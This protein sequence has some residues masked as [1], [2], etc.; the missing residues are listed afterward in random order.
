MNGDLFT[1][2]IERKF[3]PP[4]EFQVT[5]HERLRQGV[6]E[7]HRKQL[8]VAPTGAGKCL[9]RDTPVLMAD[10]TILPVQ[11]VQ[12]G[13]RLLGPDGG[14]RNVLSVARGREQLYR[15]IPKKGASYVCNA[16]HI[17][18]LRKT[19]GSDA[20]VLADGT[21][22]DPDAD[23]VNV[24][25][26]VFA[27]SNKTARHCL[28]GWRSEAIEFPAERDDLMLD[29]YLLGC[30]LGDGSQNRFAI[31]KPSCAMVEEW[32]AAAERYGYEVIETS[33]TG[34]CP[35]WT[36]VSRELFGGQVFNFYLAALDT[37]GL[38]A[39]KHIPH[40]YKI[41]PLSARLQLLAG[42]ID[43]DGSVGHAG[44]DWISKWRELAED[45][46]F[47]CR[48]VGLS[49]YVAPAR[50][51]IAATG[52]VGDYW[53][54][55]VSGDCSVIPCRDKPAPARRQKKRHLVHG[56]RV[57][58]IGEGEYFGFEIDGD[59]LFLLGDFT[60]THN[61]YL[62]LRIC[63]EAIQRGKRTLFVCDRTA[64]IEQTS[65]RA[66]QYGLTHHGIVQAEHWRRD[67]HAPL[68]IA[69]VQTLGARGYWP[70]AD[71]TVIDEAHTQYKT[72]REYI[73]RTDAVVVGLT[74]TPCTKGLGQSYDHVVNAATMHELTEAG[75]LVPLRIFTCTTPDMT[76]A[77]TSGGEWTD[78]AAAERSAKIIGDVVAEY[79]KFGEGR[80]SIAFGA[81]IAY[82]TELVERFN[83]AGIGAATFTSETPGDERAQLLAEFRK[84]DSSIRVLVSVDAL[85]KGFD[86]EDIGCVIDARPLRKSLS[87]AIQMWGRG[88][89]SSPE[90]GKRDCI[91]LDHSGNILRFRRD[92]EDVFFNGFGTLDASEKLD[93][94]IRT[95]DKEGTPAC[96]SC[97]YTP[98]SK[99]CMSCGFERQ[100]AALVDEAP[101]EMREIRIGKSV[102]AADSYDLWCQICTY[103]RQ[104]GKPEK[105]KG[106]AWYRYK[107]IMGRHPPSS[108]R[109]DATPDVP[110]SRG[111]VNK[112]KSL[113]IA[114][115]RAQKSQEH[116][117]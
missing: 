10:G 48:S 75:V 17:L 113:R 102:L 77:E 54:V 74:A 106:R 108:W 100:K 109:F 20:L 27:A 52:F 38:R 11:D 82:C 24:N 50:K 101:G 83:Q 60:V 6:R 104:F 26:E 3:P 35:T 64:L 89:R 47:V 57:E 58:S 42:L 69:S 84:P 16:S 116:A 63:H 76:G 15:V 30:W 90:T 55:S 29:P 59:H 5:A 78:R 43:S 115:S 19:P 46:A 65:R 22:V 105:A 49:A 95:E 73:E 92:F 18:S 79:L 87:T 91:L 53:R 7:G 80:K 117:A 2:P 25:V 93:K 44:F 66:D 40:E 88:L 61:T 34:S 13:D 51:G 68:Q 112:I 12:V 107:D 81:T 94:T 111:T 23:V 99:R 28:K 39:R 33:G 114:W 72:T 8:L 14:P 96:P 37:Y 103:E 62:A 67:T 32:K 1:A 70:M 9:G 4:R 31:S 110:I 97:G 21:R 56:I 86:V 71:V 45:F 41:A 98:F 36:I 85:A